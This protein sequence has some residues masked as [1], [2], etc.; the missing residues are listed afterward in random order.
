[1]GHHPR[2]GSTVLLLSLVACRFPAADRPVEPQAVVSA[3]DGG[4][5]LPG[6]QQPGA[7]VS[8]TGPIRVWPGEANE[9]PD[10][11]VDGRGDVW[12]T[13]VDFTSSVEHIR[14]RRIPPPGT[15]RPE[16]DVLL[17]GER[18]IRG[19]PRLAPRLE[20]VWLVWAE[21]REGVFRVLLAPVG[22]QGVGHRAVV[23]PPGADGLR[24]RVATAP[25]G[26]PWVVWEAR[27]PA[28]MTVMARRMSDPPR[29]P[30]VLDQA[31]EFA[32]RPTL[33][34]SPDG[35]PVAAWD[36]Y[37]NAAYDILIAALP[38]SGIPPSRVEPTWVTR[39]AYLDQAP[40]IL[41]DARETCW[42]AWHSNRPDSQGRPMLGRRLVLAALQDGQPHLPVAGL[43]PTP[44]AIR[45]KPEIQDCIE[46]PHLVQDEQ[47]RL[48]L[49]ARRG[50]GF[51]TTFLEGD[52]WHGP[53]TLSRPGWGG[54]GR[55]LH[56]ARGPDGT[57]HLAARWLHLLGRAMLRPP[58]SPARPIV[59]DDAPAFS[60]P[61]VATPAPRGPDRDSRR[62]DP[63]SSLWRLYF[64]DLHTHCWLSDATGDPDE[65][66]TRSRDLL[67]QDFVA[68]TDHDGVNGNL[69]APCQWAYLERIANFFHR[70]GRFVTILGYEWTSPP[71]DRGGF[72][73]RN[74]YFGQDHVQI[75]RSQASAPDT[76]ALFSR[77]RA[78]GGIAIP[79]HTSWT[80]TDWDAFDQDLQPLFEIV[81]VHGCSERPGARPIVPRVG[82][83]G[84]YAVEGL[85]RGYRFGFVGG[86]DGHG[87]PWHYG[88]SRQADVWTTGLTGIYA[89]SLTR[90]DLW[91]AMKQR[92]TFATSGPNI[93]VWIQAGRHIMG[94]TVGPDSPDTLSIHVVG[95]APLETVDLVHDGTV[96]VSVPLASDTSRLD[97]S[98]RIKVE[99][100]VPAPRTGVGPGRVEGPPPGSERVSAHGH[101]L[102][103]RVVQA[104][105]TMAW[106]SPIWF[107]DPLTDR[108]QPTGATASNSSSG[109]L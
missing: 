82:K 70:P 14:L 2:I 87:V 86:S 34:F 61:P 106:S 20:G 90:R 58:E 46:F 74:I 23:S 108:L 30:I 38:P 35:S 109:D 99:E 41:F 94:Q 53:V 8:W 11:T 51:L 47:G 81:S 52:T 24:P 21:Q 75:F 25:D 102:Y 76:S 18:R 63:I 68:L 54:R 40:D 12:I 29:P 100:E 85:A 36:H 73:H 96:L 80:G 69:L 19:W 83:A 27:N 78:T 10:I 50:Q 42:I 57:L 7:G 101:A 60:S 91:N 33:T 22:E 65:V 89:R 31:G 9:Y 105:G 84:T 26:I 49:F 4:E 1:M 6:W 93:V 107:Q 71:V 28:R 103:L 97:T 55:E 16:L 17:Q 98:W 66:F 92:R 67:R 44:P 32:L 39:D 13:W 45:G 37:E 48:F 79:H 95:T 88:V 43:P 77:I 15:G 64:G 62:L 5:A 56:A 72:G 59:I 104:D 3:R